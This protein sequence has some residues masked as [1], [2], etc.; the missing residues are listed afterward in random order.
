[1]QNTYRSN[2]DTSTIIKISGEIGRVAFL[3]SRTESKR[4][5]KIIELHALREWAA[6]RKDAEVIVFS[7][8]LRNYGES[9]VMAV[10]VKYV[11]LLLRH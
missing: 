1:M 11:T 5:A 9:L 7:A 10:S 8:R 4:C 3:E 2:E 6:I